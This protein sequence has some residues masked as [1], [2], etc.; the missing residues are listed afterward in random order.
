LSPLK[1]GCTKPIHDRALLLFGLT[2][3]EMDAIWTRST[4]K[5]AEE[6]L[7]ELEDVRRIQV[8]CP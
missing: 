8:N 4:L 2:A 6:L 5:T 1:L 3:P 7:K